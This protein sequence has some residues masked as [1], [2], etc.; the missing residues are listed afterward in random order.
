MTERPSLLSAIVE[1]RLS[2]REELEEGL[3]RQLIYGGDLPTQLLELGLVSEDGLRASLV[4]STGLEA[5][6][7]PHELDVDLTRSAVQAG[8]RVLVRRQP[9]ASF[10]VTHHEPLSDATRAELSQL[11]GGPLQSRIDLWFRIEETLANL[12][13]RRPPTRV[14]E[15]LD[16]W[17]E[18]TPLLSE[19]PL[20][21]IPSAREPELLDVS[22]PL[23]PPLQAVPVERTEF[24]SPELVDGITEPPPLNYTELR[25]KTAV[26]LFTNEPPTVA[27]A[28]AHPERIEAVRQALLQAKER[29]AILQILLDTA[30]SYFEYVAL[31]AVSG[32]EARGLS[33]RGA[34]ADTIEL[35]QLK[36][37]LDLAS[38]FRKAVSSHV[39]QLVRLRA[40]GLEGGVAHDLKRESGRRVLLLPITLRERTV[41]LLWGDRGTSDVELS[42]IGEV[43]SLAPTVSRA[44]ERVLLER[45]RASLAP[46]ATEALRHIAELHPTRT[47]EAPKP[48]Q[49]SVASEYSAPDLDPALL[50]KNT[51]RPAEPTT[52]LLP[53][54]DP[55]R[56]ITRRPTP[57]ILPVILEPD[58]EESSTDPEDAE[59]KLRPRVDTTRTMVPPEARTQGLP[60]AEATQLD[61]TEEQESP[62]TRHEVAPNEQR[63]FDKDPRFP[64]EGP[65][66]LKGFPGSPHPPQVAIPELPHPELTSPPVVRAAHPAMT[67]R[68]IVKLDGPNGPREPSEHGTSQSTPT[69]TALPYPTAPALTPPGPVVSAPLISRRPLKHEPPEDGWG[70]IHS[71]LP[72]RAQS[73]VLLYTDLVDALCR[74]EPYALERLVDGGENAV[75]ALI[76]KFPGP[77]T[78]PRNAQ[79]KASD[80]GPILRALVQLGGKSTPFLTVRTADEDPAVRRWATLTLGE[81]PSR[82]A[83][84]AIAGRLLDGSIEVR[85]AAL[86]SAR[87]LLSDTMARRIL[88]SQVEEL[89]LDVKL[90]PESRCA[91][92][93]ALADIREHEAIPTLLQLLGDK[94]RSVTRA[95]QWAL[96]VLTRQDFGGDFAAWQAFWQEHR[97]EPRV[98]WLI[99]SLNHGKSDLRRAAHEELKSATGQDFGFRE[100]LPEEERREI[101]ALIRTWW[102]REGQNGSASKS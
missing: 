31:F 15:L 44:L 92:I 46:E 14:R 70:E 89:A 87:R 29:D 95:S 41:L 98:L 45:K 64:S 35:S 63:P 17:G 24:S 54:H 7:L 4:R 20:S 37:P 58:A 53:P 42:Q 11:L 71:P 83:A 22:E 82:D 13:E 69:L 75:A 48:A 50:A 51:T 10:L 102:T 91:A 56:D 85:R 68:R 36:L 81:L 47:L 93:E 9:N 40:S 100:D 66:T 32:Q 94:D 76:E 65:R 27:E 39:H 26:E 25:A 60:R 6:E 43:L 62:S 16:T 3:V 23:P 99:D 78:E 2:T 52:S 86:A 90:G 72:S 84:R 80:S 59:K 49:I 12:E 77:V 97:N 88:R 8:H 101:Q 18:L 19:E 61:E 21:S 30:A 57:S 5:A 55:A 79:S 33:A 96:S 74:D 67:P 73:P 1:L 38:P 28:E 34:G